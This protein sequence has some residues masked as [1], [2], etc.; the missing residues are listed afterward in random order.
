METAWPDEAINVISYSFLVLVVHGFIIVFG[1]WVPSAFITV[2]HQRENVTYSLFGHKCLPEAPSSILCNSVYSITGFYFLIS[3]IGAFIWCFWTQSLRFRY[4]FTV[5][6]RKKSK[7]Y[8]HLTIILLALNCFIIESSLFV[9]KTFDVS[10]I[11]YIFITITKYLHIL[12]IIIIIC[13]LRGLTKQR[14]HQ[15]LDLEMPS[16]NFK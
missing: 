14:D 13:W 4:K 2:A 3:F 12:S 11:P 15:R 6:Q 5:C 7:V 10:S 8:A 16:P 9:L 1:G